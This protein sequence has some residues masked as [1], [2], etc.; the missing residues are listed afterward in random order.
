[1]LKIIAVIYI[2][3][4]GSIFIIDITTAFV[5][6]YSHFHMGRWKN[7]DKWIFAVK[8]IC[9]RWAIHTPTL[10]I[11]KDCR[12]LLIDKV[13]RNYGKK[14]VQSW[15][16]AGCLLGLIEEDKNFES[17]RIVSKVKKQLFDKNGL[18]KVKPDRIDYA[19]LAYSVLSI[20]KN[21]ELIQPGM[22]QM[23]ECIE[24]NIC[25]DGL[26]SYSAGNKAKRR[27][28]DTLGFICP[29]LAL[30]GNVY[31]E[32]K[33][34]HMAMNQILQFRKYGII[35]QLPTHCYETKTN[36]PIG[37][38]GWGRGVGWY[39]LALT[40]LYKE[41]QNN[42]DKDLIKEFMI[43]IAEKCIVFERKDGGFS[44]I[45]PAENVYDSS[46]TAMLGYFY[47][48]CGLW[49]SNDMYIKIAKKC[50][51]RL[52][53]VTK[54]NGVIDECQGDTI[55]IGIFSEK[56]GAMPFVQ[57]MTLRLAAVLNKCEEVQL[58]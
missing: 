38:I 22:L 21:P 23:I 30:Y 42:S 43:E 7:L 10:R 2:M 26:V 33:Y 46:A 31:G 9:I 25:D 15:Q 6:E 40:D 49:F 37:I 1:M 55:D 50:R 11:R 58:C 16:K 39:T 5:E 32:K 8:K 41:L 47:A 54:I 56:Y 29:F 12:Y 53:R 14:M 28:V 57:G 17:S 51:E 35:N 27:Y 45:L 36:L 3:I 44:S 19:M 13:R 18:W 48:N 4:S 24:K 52:M 34:I 20:E